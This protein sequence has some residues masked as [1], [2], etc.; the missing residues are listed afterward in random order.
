MF[1]SPDSTRFRGQ[2]TVSPFHASSYMTSEEKPLELE[3]RDL[4]HLDHVTHTPVFEYSR[5]VIRTEQFVGER[6]DM[7]RINKSLVGPLVRV[8][9]TGMSAV[10]VPKHEILTLRVPVSPKVDT[11]IFSFGMATTVP[12]MRDSTGGISH[13]LPNSNAPLHILA[14]AHEDASKIETQLRQASM[15]ITFHPDETPFARRYFS[16]IKKL[17]EE[18]SPKTQ[19]LVLADDD[20]FFPSLTTLAS[21][22]TRAYDPSTLI[23]IGALSDDLRVIEQYGLSASGG[24]GIFISVPLAAHLVQPSIWEKCLGLPNNEGDELL[25]SCLN[26]FTQFKPTFEPLLHQMDIYNGDDS[27]PEAGYI[28]SGRQLLSVHHWKTWYEFDVAK[29]AAVAR[30]TGDEG[31]FQRWLFD[32]DT[33]LSNGYSVVE[34]PRSGEYGGI[35]EKELAEVEYTWNEGD[36]EEMWRYVHMM[37]PLRPRKTSEK[38]RSARL[39]DAMEVVAPEGRGV[40]QVYV[41]KSVK[42]N[43]AFR[44]R[45]RVVELLWLL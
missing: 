24:G 19:W 7:T 41:E 9:K 6:P 32:G 22:L 38:K 17:Y 21:H 39:V 40:R 36:Q 27:P 15:N 1:S 37:G 45:D 43:T 42:N 12:R 30:A 8:R 33:V 14:P 28:E 23:I 34:Y 13:W 35:T 3:E 20:T 2:V 5:R 10:A 25:D 18:R 16:L 4:M 11:G 26:K 44:P 29:G 31:V